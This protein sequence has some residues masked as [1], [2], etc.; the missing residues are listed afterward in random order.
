MACNT[1]SFFLRAQ[2][3]K[4]GQQMFD[5]LIDHIDETAGCIV[6]IL[7][8][9]HVGQLLIGRYADDLLSLIVHRSH[10]PVR[11]VAVEL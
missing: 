2:L 9:D 1:L 3:S 6:S 11:L 10:L 7:I 4:L 5:H 8:L